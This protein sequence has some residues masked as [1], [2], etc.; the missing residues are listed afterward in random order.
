LD[1]ET[2]KELVEVIKEFIRE[3][4]RLQK[5]VDFFVEYLDKIL[6]N[7]IV[8]FTANEKT[9]VTV[10]TRIRL[11]AIEQVNYNSVDDLSDENLLTIEFSFHENTIKF[12]RI[13]D[14]ASQNDEATLQDIYMS[15][16]RFGLLRQRRIKL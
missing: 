3:H 6:M 7:Q 2:R 14:L 10:Q 12:S 15:V 4:F 9:S 5:Q 16:P 8:S 1:P 11:D 13:R